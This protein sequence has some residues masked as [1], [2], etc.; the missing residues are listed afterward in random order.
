MKS[1]LETWPRRYHSTG[2]GDAFLFYVVFGPVPREFSIS[3]SRYR[4]DDIPQELVISS[5]GPTSNPDAVEEFRSGY[6]WDQFQQANMTVAHD[7]AKQS[8]CLVIQGTIPDP[9]DL[10]Y[11]RNVVGLITWSLDV[12][13]VGIF[14]PQMFKW[15]TPSEWR[16]WIFEP[17]SAVPTHHVMIL[18]SE[19]N[20]GTSWFHTRGMRKFGRPDLSVHQVSCEL[21]D[22]IVDLLN[23]FIEFQ[24]FGGI[25]AEGQEIKMRSLPAGMICAHQ[26]SMDDPEFN[27]VH[28]EIKW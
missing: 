13:S 8:T 18:V 23:R 20:D 9:P 25:I 16:T 17:A 1:S 7:V 28:V 3:G 6:L 21:R 22:G 14:D 19:E 4:C 11:L 2:G 24:A 27:N 12:G 26:G 10:N 15:W 5:Y